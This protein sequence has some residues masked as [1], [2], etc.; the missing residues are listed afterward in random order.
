VSATDQAAV[1]DAVAEGIRC[2]VADELPSATADGSSTEPGATEPAPEPS[3]E[4]G[5]TEAPTTA[6]G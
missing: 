2:S 1:Q 5:A 3:T 6:A 4:P